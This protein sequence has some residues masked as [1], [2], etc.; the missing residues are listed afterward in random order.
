VESAQVTSFARPGAL[1]IGE[2]GQLSYTNDQFYEIN[3][4]TVESQ[5]DHDVVRGQAKRQFAYKADR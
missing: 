5:G 1:S 4:V 3:V 2:R